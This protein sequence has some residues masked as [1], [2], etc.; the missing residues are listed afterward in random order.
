MRIEHV[1]AGAWEN[2]M[3][4]GKPD[5]ESDWAWINMTNPR[6]FRLH[7]DEAARLN[8]TDSV[9][10]KPGE[11][12]SSMLGVIHNLHCLRRLRQMLYPEYY[13]PNEAEDMKQ[14][15]FGH[16]LHCLEALRSSV[17]CYPDLNPHPFYWS[18]MKY[19]DITVSAKVTRQC[20]D[21]DVMQ[22]RLEPRNFKDTEL[23]RGTG[24]PA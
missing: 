7:P 19:H 2:Q 6:T 18:G 23:M 11:D 13:Y 14:H 15:N 3:Y 9:M 16:A 24:P 17:M 12:F 8:F 5:Y 10:V 21:W 1:P 4:F 20:V 22:E